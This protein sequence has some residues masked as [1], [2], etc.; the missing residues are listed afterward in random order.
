MMIVSS[1]APY[2]PSAERVDVVRHGRAAAAAPMTR[3]ASGVFE[4]VFPGRKA[5]FDYRLRVAYPGGF[6]TEID[7]PYRYGRVITESM[8]TC[9]RRASTRGFT[10]SSART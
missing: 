9:S 5:I 10:T 3:H 6:V 4:S 2:Q 1:S 8:S 7:D